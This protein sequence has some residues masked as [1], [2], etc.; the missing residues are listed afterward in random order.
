M[1]CCGSRQARARRAER[2]NGGWGGGRRAGSFARSCRRRA[3]LQAQPLQPFHALLDE[4]LGHVAHGA[5]FVLC[6]HGEALAEVLGKHH[7][8]PGGLGAATGGGLT[9]GHDPESLRVTKKCTKAGKGSI[10]G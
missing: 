6:Q 5:G 8:D 4:H 3:V 2:R 10:Q 9:G 7:L 1:D